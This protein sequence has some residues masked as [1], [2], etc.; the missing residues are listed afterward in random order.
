MAKATS[1]KAGAMLCESLGLDPNMVRS[2]DLHAEAGHVV[3]ATVQYVHDDAPLLSGRYRL[4]P[5][6]P[7]ENLQWEQLRASI[8]R[9]AEA[10]ASRVSHRFS[11]I[12]SELELSR[13]RLTASSGGRAW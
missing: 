9:E 6:T 12:A 5:L 2:I 8:R 3:V 4:V 1:N 11:A 7:P 10:A 13:R